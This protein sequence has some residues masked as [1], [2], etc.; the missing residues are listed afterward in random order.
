MDPVYV[1]NN[2]S[3]AKITIKPPEGLSLGV[4][5][6]RVIVAYAYRN[7]T[8]CRDVARLATF[9]HQ[10]IAETEIPSGQ[11]FPM[12]FHVFDRNTTCDLI[13]G[14]TPVTGHHYVAQIWERPPS[15]WSRVKAAVLGGFT[16]GSCGVSFEETGADGT[17]HKMSYFIMAA[18]PVAGNDVATCDRSHRVDFEAAGEGSQ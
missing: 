4:A 6:S 16:D 14:F 13:G 8:A 15:F 3:T 1:A 17:P 18:E 12:L 11:E 7:T 2:Q 9:P 5:S 10:A